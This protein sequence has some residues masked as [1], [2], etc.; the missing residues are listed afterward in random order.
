MIVS[1]AEPP[2]SS[3]F[4]NLLE[5][6][7]S[8]SLWLHLTCSYCPFTRRF[9][10]FGHMM[11]TLRPSR[12]INLVIRVTRVRSNVVL[13]RLIHVYVY[14][15]ITVLVTISVPIFRFPHVCYLCFPIEHKVNFTRTSHFIIIIMYIDVVGELL[16][17]CQKIH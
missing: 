10:L 3:R 15:Y 17:T 4:Q 1:S 7:A 16:M 6:V 8:L 5:V 2:L 11:R 9:G 14:V 12:S 13:N